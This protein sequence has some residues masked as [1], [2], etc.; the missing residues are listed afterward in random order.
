[1]VS[2]LES[3]TATTRPLRFVLSTPVWGA[4][5]I[6]LYLSVGLP[7]LL[8]PGNL[9][10]L[11][12]RSMSRYL[13]HTRPQDVAE[14]EVS[15][16]YHRLAGIVPVAIRAIEAPITVP[17]RTMSDCH[18]DAMAEADASGA[19][20]IFLPPDCVWSDGS[21]DRLVSIAETGKSVVHMCGVRLDRDSVVPHLLEHSADGSH[22][23]SIG[24]R[25]LVALGLE[26]LHPIAYSHFWNE[27]LGDLMPANLMWTVPGEGLLLRCFHLHPLMVKSQVPF[28]AFSSTIDDDL[29]PRACP[30]PSGDYVVADSDELLAFELSGRDRVVGTICPKGSLHGVASW[31]EVGTNAR[32]RI[33]ID[34]PIRVHSGPISKE[35]WERCIADSDRV[36][37]EIAR[38]NALPTH[39]L[40]SRHGFHVLLGRMTA[41]SLGR[42]HSFWASL[43]FRLRAGLESIGSKV[44]RAL[45]LDGPDLR[46][47][48]R[49]WLVRRAAANAVL[50]CLAPADRTLALIGARPGLANAIQRARPGLRVLELTS[51]SIPDV[52][53]VGGAGR[54][55]VGIAVDLGAHA[56]PSIPE[57]LTH[58]GTRWYR[59]SVGRASLRSDPRWTMRRIGGLGTWLCSALF[60]ARRLSAK[61]LGRSLPAPARIVRRAGVLVLLPLFY[62]VAAAVGLAVN[63]I[64][65]LLDS[66][67]IAPRSPGLPAL[68][69]ES[70]REREQV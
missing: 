36:V 28:A 63:A 6:G 40:L 21:L 47:T 69:A 67:T 37:P 61:P 70:V 68:A 46:M 38:L 58:T 44:H 49:H 66:L 41:A 29:A 9:P 16:V 24:A 18:I 2:N 43:A 32:H 35:V 50:D 51:T 26:H 53:A 64:G 19:A 20:A 8:A 45:F 60:M 39:R 13:I 65:L 31:A 7:S 54:P 48:H 15:P 10:A 34:T 55:D 25:R 22:R 23:L 1:M 62:P 3:G 57:D 14:I 56:A 27:H 11:A 52:V 59:L 33:L 17:H 5:H 12:R 30:D 4:N 42:N